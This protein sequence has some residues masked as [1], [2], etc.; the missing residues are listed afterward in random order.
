MKSIRYVLCLLFFFV[1][2]TTYVYSQSWDMFFDKGKE[3][4]NKG[5]YEKAIENLELYLKYETT[6]PKAEAKHLLEHAKKRLIEQAEEELNFI[7]NALGLNMKMI[8]VEGGTFMMGAPD[9]DNEA[10]SDEKP[11][12]QV[13]LDSYYIAE[14]EI[15]QSQWE[16]VMGTTI[17]Q[18][19]ERYNNKWGAIIQGG[20]LP[21][22]GIG[23]KYPM[24]FL[25]WVDADA[26]C[27][28]LSELTGKNYQLPT[29]AQWEF[30]ARGGNKSKGY[31]Y[32][33]SNNIDEVAHYTKDWTFENSD[34]SK[35]H[36][37][38]QKR[39]NELGL[40]D[41]SGNVAEWCI[42]WDEDYK[43]EKQTNPKGPVNGKYKV[44]RGGNIANGGAKI[45]RVT[46]RF[47]TTTESWMAAAV[48][49][50]VVC[51]PN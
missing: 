29:E 24:Y 38:G 8:Y 50:R 48:G 34:F 2:A 27:K 21:L 46:S 4:Y 20:S 11:Q 44:F 36:P 33:G 31:K 9:D 45:C 43:A 19:N 6:N 1:V 25:D 40:Y 18:L 7:E 15:T 14:F 10:S 17:H 51:I 41:M 49:F 39:D 22:I 5:N 37:V 32:S 12:H 23:E 42:N 26:F 3:L 47:A 28:K 13:S 30:A 35:T 16:K